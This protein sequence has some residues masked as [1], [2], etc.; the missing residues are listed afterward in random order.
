[1]CKHMEYNEF[2]QEICLLYG[3]ECEGQGSCDLD[4]CEPSEWDIM[5]GWFDNDPEGYERWKKQQEGI[6]CRTCIHNSKRNQYNSWC[7]NCSVYELYDPITPTE[8]K[9]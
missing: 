8:V 7:T 5:N 4:G 1:M 3:G 2:N 9:T 6:S